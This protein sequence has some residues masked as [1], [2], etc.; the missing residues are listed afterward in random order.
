MP[1]VFIPNSFVD[2]GRHLR[3]VSLR[4]ANI[5]VVLLVPLALCNLVLKYVALTIHF[6]LLKDRRIFNNS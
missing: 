2:F 6:I 5:A 3:C 1:R 4:D